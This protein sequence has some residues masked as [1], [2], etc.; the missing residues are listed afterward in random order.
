MFYLKKTG[1][2]VT[3]N[4]RVKGDSQLLPLYRCHLVVENLMNVS[5]HPGLGEISRHMTAHLWWQ[6][7]C[8]TS[9]FWVPPHLLAA[10]S[11][12]RLS[13]MLTVSW[14][15]KLPSLMLSVRWSRARQTCTAA[16]QQDTEQ[17]PDGCCRC[18]ASNLLSCRHMDVRREAAAAN[19]P[20]GCQKTSALLTAS[21]GGQSEAC[22]DVLL[23][24]SLFH[25]WP[26]G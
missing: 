7:W 20:L 13:W 15:Q 14:L 25:T 18:R 4:N 19:S 21:R 22:W 2:F 23:A 11:I 1:R 24:F 9:V 17:R 3:E 5:I 12:L 10:V 26:A 16:V 8:L 6:R